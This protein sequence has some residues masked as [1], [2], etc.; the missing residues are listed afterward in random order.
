MEQGSARAGKAVACCEM[1]G[2]TGMA[3][4]RSGVAA[5]AWRVC[6]FWNARM[7]D[8][9]MAQ[10]NPGSGV[11]KKEVF[12]EPLT[13]PSPRWRGIREDAIMIFIRVPAAAQDEAAPRFEKNPRANYGA[14]PPT[15]ISDPHQ[16]HCAPTGCADCAN[17]FRAPARTRPPSKVD[18]APQPSS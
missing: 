5:T 10:W 1:Q 9:G 16:I 6:V 11:R 8:L 18:N 15:R 2:W 12:V 7:E 17:N 3:Q 13:Y 4:G 14:H